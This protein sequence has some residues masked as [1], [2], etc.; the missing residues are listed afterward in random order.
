MS[1]NKVF[2]LVF[3]NLNNVL[4]CVFSFKKKVPSQKLENHK[5]SFEKKS[6]LLRVVTVRSIITKKTFNHVYKI[7]AEDMEI[8]NL[9]GK[10]VE[11]FKQ[12]A[13]PNYLLQCFSM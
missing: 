2:K 4:S 10:P 13:I 12:S 6:L 8:L 7:A 5:D 9:T 11:S 3:F 1:F